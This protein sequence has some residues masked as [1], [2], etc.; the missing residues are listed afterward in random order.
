MIEVSGSVCG[1]EE[2]VT[3]H[4][5]QAIADRVTAGNSANECKR[6]EP[7]GDCDSGWERSHET[8]KTS[9]CPNQA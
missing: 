3:G 2:T 9:G 1:T 5:L 8:Y 4:L 6:S 7:S